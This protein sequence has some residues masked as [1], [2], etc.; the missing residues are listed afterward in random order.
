MWGDQSSLWGTGWVVT[1]VVDPQAPFEPAGCVV[2]L[3]QMEWLWFIELVSVSCPDLISVKVF[4]SPPSSAIPKLP[5]ALVASHQIVRFLKN[6]Q[7]CSLIKL[8]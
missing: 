8:Y 2:E 5:V 3:V 1:D 7:L 6:A 4:L